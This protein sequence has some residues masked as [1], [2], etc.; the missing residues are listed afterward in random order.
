[1]SEK[2]K[3][4]PKIIPIIP[5]YKYVVVKLLAMGT[6]I[7]KPEMQGELKQWPFRTEIENFRKKQSQKFLKPIKVNI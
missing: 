2:D 1:M 5:K 7:D 3:Q 4:E 6:T